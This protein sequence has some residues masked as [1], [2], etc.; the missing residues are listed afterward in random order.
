MKWLIATAPAVYAKSEG[1]T[2][3]LD[4]GLSLLLVGQN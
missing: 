3:L 4:F 1:K 2:D